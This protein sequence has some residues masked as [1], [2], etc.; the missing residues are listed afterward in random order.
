MVGVVAVLLEGVAP[1][2]P[3]SPAP[4]P[5]PSLLL[6]VV[7][8]LVPVVALLPLPPLFDCVDVLVVVGEDP[9]GRPWVELDMSLVVVVDL[10]VVTGS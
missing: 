8:P 5:A 9:S 7:I 4:D 1:V 2:S 10:F 3:L 6:L